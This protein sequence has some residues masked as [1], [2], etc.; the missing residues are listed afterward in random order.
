MRHCDH[1]W[2]VPQMP[3]I[4][5]AEAQQVFI[6]INIAQ[7]V[8]K[9]KTSPNSRNWKWTPPNFFWKN[10]KLLPQDTKAEWVKNLCDRELTE[11]R[12][13]VLSKG[14]NFVTTTSQIS[15][16]E[17]I[18]ETEPAMKTNNPTITTSEKRRAVTCL[19]NDHNIHY[20]KLEDIQ[21][22]WTQPMTTRS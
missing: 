5:P 16:V 7:T 14:P 13:K 1:I 9:K 15:V 6:Y 18:T 11:V 8:Q 4:F 21:W 22:S 12:K 20:P 2:K 3:Q 19:Q 17:F 10:N